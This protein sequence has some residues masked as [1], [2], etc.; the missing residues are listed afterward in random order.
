MAD[1]KPKPTK[2]EKAVNDHGAKTFDHANKI[3]ITG[4]SMVDD[5]LSR[6][7]AEQ[8]RRWDVSQRLLDQRTQN[9]LRLER[10]DADRQQ[11][12]IARRAAVDAQLAQFQ[13]A[14]AA[15]DRFWRNLGVAVVV[16]VMA[17]LVATVIY[18]LVRN[19]SPAPPVNSPVNPAAFMAP[20]P[21][22]VPAPM[23]PS[24]VDAYGLRLHPTEVGHCMPQ[25]DR[26]PMLAGIACCNRIVEGLV[27][28]CVENDPRLICVTWR[29]CRAQVDAL[30][31]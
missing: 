30:A 13:Q 20:G 1:P 9:V 23:M 25:I 10:E 22:L 19:P 3:A 31:R 2:L 21:S 15:R 17:A 5:A 4:L 7:K 11:A 29:T 14:Q 26:T 27:P 12:E 28:F 24:E 6:D 18:L 16:V 8:E